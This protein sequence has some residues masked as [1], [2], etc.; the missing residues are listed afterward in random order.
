[1]RGLKILSKTNKHKEQEKVEL[2]LENKQFQKLLKVSLLMGIIIVSG[3]IV[4]YIW[5]F[6]FSQEEDY[7]GFG[8]LNHRKEAEDY[9]TVA[10]VNQT[11]IFYVTVEWK[12]NVFS[13][14]FTFK[15]RVYRGGN[16]T[17]LS[18]DGSQNA[19]RLY[20]T[21]KVTL[22]PN[23]EWESDELSVS[24]PQAG[25][26]QIIIVELWEYTDDEREFYDILW[27]RLKII[28]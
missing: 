10:Y 25:S 24:F 26:N 21:D 11:V 15:V 23:E 18:S 12:A 7:V 13:G 9:P 14:D 17:E 1:M 16:Q 19:E 5:Y 3:F 22:K 8:V 6:N 28:S 20:S 4:Y 27:L 2:K